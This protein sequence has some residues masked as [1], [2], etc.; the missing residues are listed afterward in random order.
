VPGALGAITLV[1]VESGN[2]LE[3]PWSIA[4]CMYIWL[5]YCQIRR[6]RATIPE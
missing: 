2:A 6:P 4:I 5:Q 3:H 1:P